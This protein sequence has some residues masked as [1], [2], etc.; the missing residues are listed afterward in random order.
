M[1]EFIGKASA[2]FRITA[3]MVAVLCGVEAAGFFATGVYYRF[4]ELFFSLIIGFAG[5]ALFAL[6]L[7]VLSSYLKQLEQHL[8]K[9]SSVA[10][11]LA[12]LY[13]V[14][15]LW[16]RREAFPPPEP[17][18][19]TLAGLLILMGLIIGLGRMMWYYLSRVYSDLVAA[20]FQALAPVSVVCAGLYSMAY[21]SIEEIS[22]LA[23][24]TL[25]IMVL[26]LAGQY[27]TIRFIWGRKRDRF[28]KWGA[29]IQAAA[30]LLAVAFAGIGFMAEKAGERRPAS[31]PE[32]SPSVI[33]ITIDT[34]RADY[35]SVNNPRAAPTPV[36]DSF[37]G[38]GIRFAQAMAPASWTPPS[39]ASIITGLYP[40]ACGSGRLVP[41]ERY[42]FTGPLQGALTLAEVFR[43]AG[44]VTAAFVDNPW[45]G[46]SHNYDQGF[47]VF[48]LMGDVKFTPRFL[49]ARGWE[50]LYR[51]FHHFPPYPAIKLTDRTLEWLENRPRGPFFLWLHYIDPHLPYLLHHEYSPR[52]VPSP[53]GRIMGDN[54]TSLRVRLN[55][56]N[57]SEKDRLYIRERYEGEVR[58]SDDELARL[59]S[60]VK[61]MGLYDN[62]AIVLTADH[63]EE[64]WEHGGFAHAHSFYDE[65]IRVPLI[66]KLPGN[67]HA[68]RVV[69]SWVSTIRIGATILDFLK[70]KSK[71]PGT[72]LLDCTDSESCSE[73]TPTGR[74]WFS[75][76]TLMGAEL[77]AIGDVEG[78][79]AI[80]HGDGSITCYDRRRD[81][82]EQQPFTEQSCPWPGDEHSPRDLFKIIHEMNHRTFLGLGGDKEPVAGA[83]GEEL[84][85]L[86]ALGYI[87]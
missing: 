14:L 13:L 48:E 1:R 71:F 63:G 31:A 62:N 82:A 87:Q 23:M 29:R 81:P 33:L 45:L 9:I 21:A 17:R 57:M 3:S 75:E 24:A 40:G 79:K 38:D 68:G 8:A 85:K 54:R 35:L 72:S 2:P 25:G 37:A 51:P 41:G 39:V 49:V 36:M 76:R 73:P 86:K 58:F 4:S 26:F 53:M 61:A 34:L 7:A 10:A 22:N 52:T 6:G 16:M 47:N 69:D 55:F 80:F 67:R 66:I 30:I 5:A 42:D 32:G 20:R 46:P 83:T 50:L 65:V 64:F 60:K 44:Y 19:F 11:S 59:L 74:F 12:V 84:R 18:W 78:R 27:L 43:E 56:F 28:V 70:I 77:G 15:V